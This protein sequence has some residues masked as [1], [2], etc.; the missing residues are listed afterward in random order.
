M[1]CLVGVA[2]PYPVGCQALP[3]VEAGGQCLVGLGHKAYG[4]G[5]LGVPGARAGSLAGKAGFWGG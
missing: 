4:C 3:C 1:N 5:N 2:G